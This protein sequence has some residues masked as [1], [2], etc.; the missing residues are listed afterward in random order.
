M[1]KFEKLFNNLSSDIDCALI[2]SDINRRYFCGMKSSAGYIVAFREKSYLLIDFRYFEKAQ[3]TVSNCEVI[4]LKNVKSQILELL[5]KH[6]AKVIGIESETMTISELSRIKTL[7]EGYNIDS[8]ENLSKAIMELRIIKTQSEIDKI[9]SAQAI[10]EK[11]FDN[12]LNFIKVGVTEKEIALQLDF[13]MLKN[14][15]EDLSFETIAL[16][17]KN[18]SLPHGVP[19]ENKVQSGDFVL[20]DYG[21]VYDGYHSDMT[22]TVC[23]GNPSCEMKNIYD[24]VLTAQEKAINAIKTGIKGKDLDSIA[25][26]YILNSGYGEYF[27]H[28]LG[29]G[30]GMEIHEY[31][32]A[33]LSSQTEFKENMIVTVEPG[34]YL[35][36]KFGVRIEDFVVVKE[37]KCKNLTKCAKKL[38]TI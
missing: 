26:N 5:I 9:A 16:T 22:R 10:A 25:R 24:V 27:G 13:Y 7:F 29:H 3:A 8:S 20:M 21:A 38:I 37:N 11:A 23:V 17:G 32:N 31:P 14:G 1:E 35:P 30:V 36:Q 34:I 2:T 28:G 18:T 19:G 4:L 6:K 12:V 15:A 33:N